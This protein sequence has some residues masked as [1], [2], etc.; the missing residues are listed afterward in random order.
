MRLIRLAVILAVSLAL[1]PL[2]GEAQQAGRVWRIGYLI[3]GPRLPGRPIPTFLDALR[4]LG[5]IEGQNL[6]VEYRDGQSD[7]RPASSV[8]SRIS[9][10]PLG[11]KKCS[12]SRGR[13]I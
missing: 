1:A 3:E 2:G 7:R 4:E 12:L 13:P 5:Y 6:I 11:H 10:R 8:Q 9:S